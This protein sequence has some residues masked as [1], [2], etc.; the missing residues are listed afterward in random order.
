MLRVVLDGL[1]SVIVAPG[2][3]ACGNP[4]ETPSRSA[5]CERCWQSIRPITPPFCSIC[6]DPLRSWRPVD[7]RTCARCSTVKR[8]IA[9]GRAVGE[10]DGAL[11][12]ILQAFKYRGRRSLAPELSAL[13]KAHGRSVLA[14]ATCVVPVP[15]HWR[16]RWRRGF[17]QA[18]ELAAG[19]GVP[20]VDALRRS[21][22]TPSQTGLPASRRHA[23]V[24]NAFLP[25]CRLR[26]ACVVLVDDV[27]T[28]GST[29]EACART[30]LQAGAREVR[31]LTAARVATPPPAGPRR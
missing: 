5:V 28:T 23:N 4:L 20:V 13:M 2:C 8:S 7:G 10:Y 16:R 26:G 21:R 15:L 12:E 30:L 17:N 29:L 18:A 22:H 6:G 14:D 24:R 27:S 9:R 31:A 3:A 1:L 19:L 11:R 25:R